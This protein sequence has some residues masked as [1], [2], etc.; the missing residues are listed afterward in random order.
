MPILEHKVAVC[1]RPDGPYFEGEWKD[2]APNG[3]G[4]LVMSD[5][6]HFNGDLRMGKLDGVGT[7]V[8]NDG[9]PD[10]T[11]TLTVTGD[12]PYAETWT[13]GCFQDGGRRTSFRVDPSS[14][15]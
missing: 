15:P 1:P 2:D 7:L 10:G 4:S 11:G 5:G 14:C 9:A 6:G 12:P 13:R 8:L 3:R